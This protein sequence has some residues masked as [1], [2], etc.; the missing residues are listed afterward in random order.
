MMKGRWRLNVPWKTRWKRASLLM[1]KFRPGID[2]ER[3]IRITCKPIVVHKRTIKLFRN[4][5]G[6]DGA[7]ELR[8]GPDQEQRRSEQGGGYAAYFA[9]REGSPPR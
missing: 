7:A 5:A 4:G 2:M 1:L 9:E 8:G 3:W 6:C